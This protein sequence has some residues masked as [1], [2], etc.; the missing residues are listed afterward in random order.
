MVVI[1]HKGLKMNSNFH[2]INN[3]KVQEQYLKDNYLIEC[4][5]TQAKDKC[6]I[7]FTSNSLYFP[8]TESV[9]VEA[10]IT[11]NRYE[12]KQNKIEGVYKHIF[13]RDIFKQW[14]LKGIN[15]KINSIEKLASF[16][17]TET[18]GYK[19]TCIGSS[20]GGYAASLLGC[21]IKAEKVLTFNGQ[22]EVA[23]LLDSEKNRLLNPL[24]VN[25]ETNNCINKY[26]NITPLISDKKTQIYYFNSAF[27]EW[28]NQQYEIVKNVS[29]VYTI[30]FKSA[31]HGIPFELV[32]MRTTLNAS[33]K[34]LQKLANSAPIAS[35]RYSIK[36]NGILNTLRHR[37]IRNLK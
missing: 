12:W 18:K 34:E 14:Y 6:V 13:V 26:Y 8:N 5:E 35:L 1:K 27:S 25:N 2:Q 36:I 3:P 30:H 9:F 4:D 32:D 15:H 17:E 10:V 23:T 33:E 29:N 16:L 37:L 21:M 11:K 20:A 31:V 7:F 24:L 19:T 22:F 28:D